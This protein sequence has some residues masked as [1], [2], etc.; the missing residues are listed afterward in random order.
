MNRRAL[1]MLTSELQEQILPQSLDSPPHPET[2]ESR[3]S[4]AYNII[5][6]TG[7]CVIH[8][9]HCESAAERRQTDPSGAGRLQSDTPRP[10]ESSA[11]IQSRL[12]RPARLS[13][14]FLPGCWFTGPGI[15]VWGNLRG[16]SDW[17]SQLRGQVGNCGHTM[18]PGG[19]DRVSWV[20]VRQLSHHI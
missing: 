6:L 18:H 15:K 8:V 4:L 14:H 5:K 2:D 10:P 17:R 16:L 13:S 1:E 9:C 20:T 11:S 12:C 19:S 7:S 3:K